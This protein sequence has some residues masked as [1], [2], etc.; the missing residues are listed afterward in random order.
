MTWFKVDDDIA[1]HPKVLQA[2]DEAMGLWLRAGGWSAQQLT[3]GFVPD[4][5]LT[6]FG[7]KPRQVK[8]LVA[9]GLWTKTAGGYQ[10]HE[11]HERQPTRSEVRATRESNAE[12][13]KRYRDR[14][15]EGSRNGARNALR[16]GDRNGVTNTAPA[17]PGPA[18]PEESSLGGSLTG[19][20]AGANPPFFF[21][22]HCEL[23]ANLAM[24][25]KCGPCADKRRAM[26]QL[27]AVPSEP[28]QRCLVHMLSHTG[29]CAGC[30]ADEKAVK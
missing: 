18:R 19:V 26:T 5:I 14:R 28:M 3:D 21:A 20:D 24:P 1:F 4:S 8:A 6:A 23:H 10:F 16:N 22:D 30:A 12:R 2:G 15:S 25:P 9:A 11:W 7:A 29:T 13:Q 27:K 17:R